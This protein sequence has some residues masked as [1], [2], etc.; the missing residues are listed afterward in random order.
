MIEIK[1]HPVGDIAWVKARYHSI[2][3]EI[4]SNWRVENGRFYIDVTIPANARTLVHIT[5]AAGSAVTESGRPAT[6]SAGVEFVGMDGGRAVFAVGSGE[7]HFAVSL[8]VADE[9]KR[10]PKERVGGIQ[11]H[12]PAGVVFE[13][14]G[15]SD[16]FQLRPPKRLV[17]G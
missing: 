7:Y 3:G 6:R 12:R 2:R 4:T 15:M 14:Q 11:R 8:P 16:E 13:R 1:P 17:F 10:G 9:L 5:A